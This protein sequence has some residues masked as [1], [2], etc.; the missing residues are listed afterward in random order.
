[1]NLRVN[2]EAKLSAQT[3]ILH[4]MVDADGES[5]DI[6]S[7]IADSVVVA[8]AIGLQETRTMYG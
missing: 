5:G 4:G 3:V 7:D 1:M 8:S 2:H 6:N